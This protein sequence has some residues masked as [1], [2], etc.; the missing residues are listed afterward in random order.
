MCLPILFVLLGAVVGRQEMIKESARWRNGE[1]GHF[2]YFAQSSD[3]FVPLCNLTSLGVQTRA[4]STILA[5][6]PASLPWT[7]DRA[8]RFPGNLASFHFS[9]WEDRAFQCHRLGSLHHEC[10]P[11]LKRGDSGICTCFKF[12]RCSS[13]V[14]A[15]ASLSLRSA[16]LPGKWYVGRSRERWF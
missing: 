13:R 14:T 2:F 16:R 3:S 6:M 1:H 11:Q 8:K 4:K 10:L 5:R 15:W 7:V 12:L 9:G